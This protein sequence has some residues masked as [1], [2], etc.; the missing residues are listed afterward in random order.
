M[1]LLRTCL[2]Q[3]TISN[4]GLTGIVQVLGNTQ[5]LGGPMTETKPTTGKHTYKLYRCTECGHESKIGTNHWGKC[6]PRCPQCGWKRPMEAG[7]RH[8]CLEECPLT[9]GTPEPWETVKLGDIC[10]IRRGRVRL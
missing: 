7:Q 4:I 1:V 2:E 6:S 10:D 9:H 5:T 8:V 3:S